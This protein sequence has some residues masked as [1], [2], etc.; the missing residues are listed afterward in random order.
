MSTKKETIKDHN[1]KRKARLR[2]RIQT[3]MGWSEFEYNQVLFDTAV[4]YME[5][6]GVDPISNFI[7][8]QQMFWNWWTNQWMIV[9]E[10]FLYMY[11]DGRISD[12]NP[13]R[14]YIKLHRGIDVYP[15][16]LIWD[17]IHDD[18]NKMFDQ[19]KS[20]HNG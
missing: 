7:L 4:W 19:L 3:L 9:D 14:E 1:L 17:A 8:L 2:Q 5:K 6:D 11:E 10:N 12:T 18:Y 13:E 20:T 16:Q 15:D